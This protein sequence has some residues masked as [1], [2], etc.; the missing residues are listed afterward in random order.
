MGGEG[1]WA[2]LV[3]ETTHVE[4]KRVLSWWHHRGVVLSLVLRLSVE[5]HQLYPHTEGKTPKQGRMDALHVGE[6]HYFSRDV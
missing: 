6:R 4:D 2:D 5:R 1:S 3:A